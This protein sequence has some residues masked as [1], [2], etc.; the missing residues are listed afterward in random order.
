MAT[1]VLASVGAALGASVA[2]P[3]GAVLA[4]AG[5]IA[6]A[7]LGGVIDR[8]VFGIGPGGRQIEGPRLGDLS[9]QSSAYGQAV[10]LVY[11][12]ARVAGNV[13]WSTGLIET[14]REETSKVK[15]GKGGGSTTV[16]NVSYLYSASFAVALA[17][18]PIAGIGRIWADG[19]L[20]RDAGGA[21][22][23]DGTLRIHPGDE[24]QLPD[25]LIEAR[26]GMGNTP[27]YRG[28][29]YVVFENLALAEY[30]NR[31][32]N[33]TFEVIADAG[34]TASLAAV[35]ADLCQRAGLMS[36]DVSALEG[37]VHGF[38]LGRQMTYRQALELLMQAYHFDAVD[39]DGQVVFAPLARSPVAALDEAHLVRDGDS[40]DVAV[41]VRT[42]EMELPRDMAVR[43]IDPARDYQVGVQ[44]ARRTIS[45]SRRSD[46]LDLP[47]TLAANDAKRAAEIALGLAWLKREQVSFALTN[48][49]LALTPGDVVTLNLAG[50]ARTL[51]LDEVRIGGGRLMCRAVP[52][53]AEAL[54]SV[55]VG[56]GGGVPPQMV[57]PV[58]STLLHLL[59]LPSVTAEDAASPVFY[60]ALT[61]ADSAWRGAALFRSTDGGETYDQVAASAAPAVAGVAVTALGSGPSDY[62][63]NANTVTVTLLN[64]AMELESRPELAVLNGANAALLG[65][66]IIQFRQASQNLDG[67]WVLSGLLRGRRGTERHISGHAIGERFVLLTAATIVPV[68]STFAALGREDLFKGVSIG[69]LVE[70]ADAFS[71]SY[72]GENLRPF[73]PAHVRAVRSSSGDLTLSWVRRS[74]VDGG[75][76]DGADVPLGEALEAYEVDIMNGGAVVR[77]L[78]VTTPSAS[79]TAAQ[80]TADFGSP[81][82]SI[83]MRI[84]QISNVVGRGHP[85]ICTV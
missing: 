57:P 19:K 40:K 82:A 59:N 34:G 32:P 10:P 11:G 20:L 33:L 84:Y 24:N 42:Q 51:Q 63:D 54:D 69:A 55:A 61:S 45:A 73:A 12:T 49:H 53:A 79:Y 30:A 67:D 8:Q 50:H 62:W 27:A 7:Q 52:Y 25:P 18:R 77:T 5:S 26:Q 60:A 17:A 23:V 22:A 43:H 74:R 2:G 83:D 71:F 48:Q 80:Q 65:D 36:F 58:V 70:N 29:A 66:E 75:W 85:A 37:D 13:I 78:S 41:T 21:L 46:T 68:S 39:I 44:R 16:T 76:A 1:L 56:D 64:A 72:T 6:G 47:L 4:V 35:V 38:V 28:L 31:I 9:V 81:Q 14:R 3:L 15:G